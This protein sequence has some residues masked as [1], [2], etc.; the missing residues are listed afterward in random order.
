MSF[1]GFLID[2]WD[3][4]LVLGLEHL[5]VV[6]TSLAL[7]SILG[8]G[9]SMLVY[10]R[11]VPR[12]LALAIVSVIFTI[13]SFALLV[14]FISPLGLGPVNVI[15]ALTLYGMLPIM[16][17]AVVG[18]RGAD[19]GVLEAARGLGLTRMQQFWKVRVP[20]AW[21]VM[22]TGLRVAALMLIGIATLGYTV[23][24]PGYGEFVFTGLY[25]VGTPVALNLVLAGLL[26]VLLVGLLSELLF[27]L[28]RRLTTPR[29]S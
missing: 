2:R 29:S 21:P 28:L 1:W 22:L 7:A 23:L 27:T 26:G 3:D 15:A 11:S 25:R 6:G 5:A 13:P 8:V 10:N 19:P 12:A 4:F 9:L 24:G 16:Q 18:L 17:N 20:L 14:L